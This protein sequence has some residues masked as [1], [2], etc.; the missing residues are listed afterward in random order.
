MD[1]YEADQV[2]YLQAELFPVCVIARGGLLGSFLQRSLKSNQLRVDAHFPPGID[3]GELGTLNDGSVQARLREPRELFTLPRD[4]EGP[5][6]T[7]R[8]PSE[9]QVLEERVHHIEYTPPQPEPYYNFSGKEPQPKVIGEESGVVIYQ[10]YPTS[11]VN[12]FSRSTAGGSRLSPPGT[13]AGPREPTS[14]DELAFES[15]FECGN[16]AKVVKITDTYYELHLRSDLY[17]NRHMQWYYFR[18][19]NTRRRFIYR[20]SIV[21]LSKGESLYTSGMRP[22]LYS[23]RDAHLHSIGWRRCGDNISFYKNDSSSDEEPDQSASYTL[24]FNIE[25]PHDRDSVYLAHCYPYTY[26]DLQDYLGRI[27]NH[28]IK[29]TFCKLR[30]LCKSLAG[31]NVY[32]LTVTAPPIENETKKKK[33]IIVTARVHPGETPASYMMKGLMDFI[34]GDSARARELR[35]KFI[36]KIV[37]ML[38]PDGVIVGNNRCSLTGRDLNRQYRTVIRE[39]YPPV[40]HTKLMIRRLMEECGVLMYCDMHAH[41]RKH[42]T[43]IYGCENKRGADKRLL[44]QVFPLMLHKNAADKF[45]FESCRFRIQRSKEGTGRVVVWLMGVAN[46]YTMEASFAG[47]ALSSRAGTH[48]TAQ[49]YENMGK[50]FC[51]TLLDYSDEDP[52]KERLRCKIITRL[53]QEGS[54]ADEPINIMLSDYSSDDGDSSSS[55][56]YDLL[57]NKKEEVLVVPPPSPVILN[58]YKKSKK[59]VR[60]TLDLPTTDPGSDLCTTEIDSGDDTEPVAISKNS[61]SPKTNSKNLQNRQNMNDDRKRKTKRRSMPPELVV[62]IAQKYEQVSD[63]E[64]YTT[65]REAEIQIHIERQSS[66]YEFPKDFPPVDKLRTCPWN[67][68]KSLPHKQFS[69]NRGDRS[70][71]LRAKLLTSTARQQVWTGTPEWG[72][73]APLSWGLS[74]MLHFNGDSTALLKSCSQKLL[75]LERM[76][77]NY[78]MKILN[79][80]KIA[81]S[82]KKSFSQS[83]A[84]YVQQSSDGNGLENRKRKPRLKRSDKAT[85]KDKP[86]IPLPSYLYCWHKGHRKRKPIAT[87]NT[88]KTVMSFAS[89]EESN[90]K[91][92]RNN[93]LK[94]GGLAVMAINN[95]TNKQTHKLRRQQRKAETSSDTETEH[96]SKAQDGKQKNK[97]KLLKSRSKLVSFDKVNKK[98]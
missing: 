50:S 67:Q 18:V 70:G 59:M 41:S 98:L 26:T 89:P 1:Y 69:E 87:Q 91:V 2:R 81:K 96:K 17:T 72:P 23:T 20:F 94:L 33:A 36:F 29:S 30:L 49:D 14:E 88:A 65:K 37:P 79:E 73:R 40:W 24:T 11:A 86:E 47:S 63:N 76:S 68:F 97:K 25:F 21:N 64:S 58:K 12:Y 48:F 16:L 60:T 54:T 13:S 71:E 83:G 78:H 62:K 22:L 38:N 55:S 9:C 8:W 74:K 3:G 61:Y 90:V 93:G 57:F 80:A 45:S 66:E 53:V 32:Y 35:A 34:T 52:S 75:T 95:N 92:S 85:S 27:Q 44:E 43:F 10:Y 56:D 6:Q 39:T 84:N 82:L 5:Q 4:P 31:N 7:A 28:P 15:R 77:L 42:N 51:E 46:S 19:S